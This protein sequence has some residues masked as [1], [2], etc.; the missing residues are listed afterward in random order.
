VIAEILDAPRSPTVSLSPDR[1]WLLVLDR[2]ALPPLAELA[3]PELR[4]AGLRVNPRN[5]C[6]SRE[7]H[8]TRLTFREMASG[9][10]VPLGA[11]PAQ[12]RL[13]E[14]AWSPDARYVA[15]QLKLPDRCELWLAGPEL[16]DPRRLCELPLNAAAGSAFDWLG[17]SRG[18][19]CRVC[20]R[21]GPLPAPLLLEEVV[22]QESTPGQPAPARTYQDL[23]KNPHDEA[24][25]EHCLTSRLA[26]VSLEGGVELIGEAGLYVRAQPSPDDRWLLVET[27]HRPFSYV[28]PASRFPKRIEVW[29]RSGRVALAVA[30][31]PLAEEIPVSRDAV[32]AG[33]RWVTWRGDAPATLVWVEAAD[34]GDPTVAAEVRDRLLVQSAPFVEPAV[35]WI[36][37]GYRLQSIRWGHGRL[38][39]LREA[40]RKT[41]RERIWRLFPDE[42]AAPPE[43]LFERSTEDR[44]GDPG[45]PLTRRNAAGWR[46]MFT[47]RTGRQVYLAGEGASPEGNRPFVDRYDLAARQTVRL[48]QS[49][50]PVYESPIAFLDADASLLLTLRE[51]IDEPPNYFVR[52]L[53]QPGERAPQTMTSGPIGLGS[54]SASEHA[55]FALGSPAG[56]PRRLTSFPHPTP[57]LRGVQRHLL[58]YARSDGVT[59]TARLYLP[60]D[61][62]PARHGPLPLVFWAYPHEYKSAEAASQMADSPYKFLP[63]GPLSPLMW[64]TQG[65]AVLDGPTMPI[66][67]EGQAEPNDQY[68]EQLVASAQ[69]AVDEV[70]R[71]GAADR[72]RMA[73]GGHSYGAFMV[74]NLLAH[75]DL[76]QAGIA[77]SGAY[78]RTLTPFGFQSEDRTLW[79]AP[80][81]YV[82]MSPLLFAHQIKRP[83]LLIHGAADENVGT[84]PQQSERFFQALKGHGAPARLVILPYEGHSYQARETIHRVAAEIFNWLSEHVAA[85]PRDASKASAAHP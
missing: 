51:S 5:L 45:Q 33:R 6:R 75:C 62:E 47:D 65:Y 11:L 31:L 56:A 60:A 81:V 10:D 73:V 13:G 42:L 70:A 18:L 76:F 58:R 8:F 72:S 52:Q 48:W 71:R 9:R 61:Y 1:R 64:V 69:A 16:P 82:R 19:V 54:A 30:D 4:L 21:I 35:P 14:V 20:E 55:F 24:L 29:D 57:Q 39:L 37:L 23:L 66:I 43:L 44:Y 63:V 84:H 7:S 41:R 25:F 77:L 74:A 17:S 68:L 28:V 67:G 3:Q 40:W 32:R 2:P 36:E 53:T 46:V 79:Q 83:L 78:N 22:A 80:E 59:C 85:L 34:E 49:T 27:I 15:M 26:R 12:S 50:P 38:A